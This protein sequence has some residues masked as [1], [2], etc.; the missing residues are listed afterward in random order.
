MSLPKGTVIMWYSGTIPTGWSELSETYNG[1]AICGKADNT[2]ADAAPSTY[3]GAAHTHTTT[4]TS[5]NATITH[6]HENSSITTG[7]GGSATVRDYGILSQ[8]ADH[9]HDH[10]VVMAILSDTSSHNHALT[11]AIGN[12]TAALSAPKYKT[13]ILIIKS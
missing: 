9:S 11:L 8:A 13:A 6:N 12:A 4:G 10:D 2:I 3:A 7:K 1:F 5:G